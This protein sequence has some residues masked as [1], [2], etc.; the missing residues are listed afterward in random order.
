MTTEITES[1]YNSLIEDL[2]GIVDG[3]VELRFIYSWELIEC[4]HRMGTRILQENDNFERSKIYGGKIV[5]RVAESIGRSEKTVYNAIKFAK[6]FPDLNL[7]P[8]GKNIVWK[9][10]IN[11]YLTAG[12]EKPVKITPTEMIRQIKQLLQTEWMK[13][14]Q[15][16]AE[17]NDPHQK[18]IC[19]FIRYLQDQVEKIAGG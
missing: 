5:Q 14:N 17:R 9:H 4:Y 19:E 13:A 6:M 18:T 3:A 1:W 2:N 11:K 15:G 7:L 12:E 8:E 10:I 16:L